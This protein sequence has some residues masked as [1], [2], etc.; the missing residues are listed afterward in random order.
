MENA[1]DLQKL[2]WTESDYYNMSWH[3]NHIHALSFQKNNK[4]LLDIDYIFKWVHKPHSR[5][6]KFWI[7]PCTLIFDNVYNMV[8]DVE[9]SSP[10]QLIIDKI[11]MIN[12]QRPKNAEYI[13]RQIE[14][15]WL[16]ETTSGEIT[17]KSVGYDQ[18]IRQPAILSK[19]QVIDIELRGGVSFNTDYNPKTE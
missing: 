13:D 18:Y 1:Y 9:I 2:L 15:D 14:Y 7:T 10:H 16:I 12:P 4:F 5:Y 8:F 3:D 11:S 19:H 17:F 6:F